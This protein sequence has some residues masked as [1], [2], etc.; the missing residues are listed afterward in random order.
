MPVG[1][2]CRTGE[3]RRMTQ[4]A[5]ISRWTPE[6]LRIHISSSHRAAAT[7]TQSGLEERNPEPYQWGWC[8]NRR[9][10]SKGGSTWSK[11]QRLGDQ[12]LSFLLRAGLRSSVSLVVYLNWPRDGLWFYLIDSRG[13]SVPLHA[14]HTTFTEPHYAGFRIH[15]SSSSITLQA[16]L[17]LKTNK[18]IDFLSLI[19]ILTLDKYQMWTK[20]EYHCRGLFFVKLLK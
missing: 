16:G 3:T 9:G 4:E 6:S 19:L 8:P 1:W 15:R 10:R 13:S 17:T 18:K 5:D 20:L 2:H 11:M 14:F 7:G 12:V